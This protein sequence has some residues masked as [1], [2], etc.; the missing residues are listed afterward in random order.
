MHSGGYQPVSPTAQAESAGEAFFLGKNMKC[1]ASECPRNS[2]AKGYCLM[3]YKRV[4]KHGNADPYVPKRVSLAERFH[5]KYQVDPG[6]G[7][8]NW[9]GAKDEKGYGAINLGGDGPAIKAHR[10]SYEIHV[11]P[12][13]QGVGFHGTC[14]LHRCDNASCVNP[15]HLFLGTVIDNNRDMHQ[16]G[17]T[18]NQT[19]V[20]TKGKV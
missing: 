19:T 11:G 7:C 6:T 5:G 4:R 16:K 3:H 15:L 9:T 13:P 18:R 20:K 1:N 12:I 2:F 10:V 8:W 14:V 17:R